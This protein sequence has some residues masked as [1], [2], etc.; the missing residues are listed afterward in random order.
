M[1]KRCTMAKEGAK[2]P[3]VLALSFSLFIANKG[4]ASKLTRKSYRGASLFTGFRKNVRES[5]RADF[6]AYRR[7]GVKPSILFNITGHKS[8]FPVSWEKALPANVTSSRLGPTRDLL[9]S[10][11]F[12]GRCKEKSEIRFA[13]QIL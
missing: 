12:C 8:F 7:I 9:F 13:G 10:N 2:I 3:E 11:R 1:Q 6:E 4:E 5:R